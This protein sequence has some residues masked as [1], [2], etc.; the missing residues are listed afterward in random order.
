MFSLQSEPIGTFPHLTH[1]VIMPQL[2]EV[3]EL[4]EA[5]ANELYAEHKKFLEWRKAEW[6][7]R[8]P[9][10]LKVRQA[11]RAATNTTWRQMKGM[12]LAMHEMNHPGNKPFVIGMG[13][14]SAVYMMAFFSQSGKWLG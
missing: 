1:R 6:A 13:V 7:T 9:E 3:G 8:G 10:A 11:T 4:T 12:Q 5:R 14:M 2:P